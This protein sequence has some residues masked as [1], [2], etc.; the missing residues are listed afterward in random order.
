MFSRRAKVARQGE[1]VKAGSERLI[2]C[3]FFMESDGLDKSSLATADGCPSDEQ[4]LD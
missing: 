2:I 1:F 3:L 4:D